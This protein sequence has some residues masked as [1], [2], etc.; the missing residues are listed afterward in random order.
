MRKWTTPIQTIIVKDADL[1][2]ADSVYVTFSYKDKRWEF[3]DLTIESDGTDSTITVPL[4]QEITGEFPTAL[5]AV[6]VN[7]MVGDNRYATDISRV[8]I[9]LNLKDEV[10]E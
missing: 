3:T 7:W 4:T 9:E 5:V 2:V 1:R 8:T 10:I 6:Q